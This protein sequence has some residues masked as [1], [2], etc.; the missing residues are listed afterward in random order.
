MLIGLG[1]YLVIGLFIYLSEIKMIN[2][3]EEELEIYDEL[4]DREKVLYFIFTVLFWGPILLLYWF[5]D[6][7]ENFQ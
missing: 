4:A 2:E 7:F 5:T 3:D 6:F 1:I